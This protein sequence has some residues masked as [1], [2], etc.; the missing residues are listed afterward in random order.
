MNADGKDALFELSSLL[1]TGLDKETLDVLVSLCELGVNPDALAEVVQQLRSEALRLE[2][3][4]E[5]KAAAREAGV[6]GNNSRGGVH[7]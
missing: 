4:A 5:S 7:R 2:Q 3:E 1:N 6:L